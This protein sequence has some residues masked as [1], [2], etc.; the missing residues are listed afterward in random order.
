LV[1]NAFLAR[2]LVKALKAYAKENPD[3][4]KEAAKDILLLR[5]P[6]TVKEALETT[7][8]KEWIEAIRKEMQSLVDKPVFEIKKL[9]AGSR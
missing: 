1:S 7:Q 3:M 5:N 9:P 6:K 2:V 8:R 4:R